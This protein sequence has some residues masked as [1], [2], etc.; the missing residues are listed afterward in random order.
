MEGR[1]ACK[2]VHLITTREHRNQDDSN[3]IKQITEVHRA[4]HFSMPWNGVAKFLRVRS[5]VA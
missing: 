2:V 4:I 5:F 3:I 1:E